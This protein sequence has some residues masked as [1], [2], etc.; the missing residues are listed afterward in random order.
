MGPYRVIFQSI[1]DGDV[2]RTAQE[3]RRLLE[4]GADPIQILD[5]SMIPAM[6]HLDAMLTS[7]ERFIPQVLLSA[8]AMQGAVQILGDALLERSAPSISR[9]TVVLGTVQGD[10][11]NIGKNLVEVLLSSVGFQVVDLGVNVSAEQ[12]IQAVRVH[13]AGTVAL[14]AM[15][16]S[17]MVSMRAV[18]QRLRREDFGWPIRII[19]GGS[20]ITAT[21]A[22]SI[23]ADFAGNI[24]E[25]VRLALEGSGS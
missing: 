24:T 21:F 10:I 5:Q 8:K 25:T 7:G 15:L 17:S 4:A 18:V 12:F 2:Q 20:P 1:M 14:S 9:G 3:C 19:V 6:D 22:R 11:H 13:R 16:T 23:H